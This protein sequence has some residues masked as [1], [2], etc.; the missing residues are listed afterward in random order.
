MGKRI[1]FFVLLLPVFCHADS[2]GQIFDDLINI[3]GSN[4]KT[5]VTPMQ[6]VALQIFALLF[7]PETIWIV[8]KKAF[9]EGDHGKATTL[10]FLRI[11]SGGFFVYWIMN[12]DIFFAIPQY[13]AQAGSK[14]G[15]FSVTPTGDF[16]IMPSAIMNL[17]GNFTDAL[18]GQMVSING[19]RDIATLLYIVFLSLIVMFCLTIISLMLTV[20]IIETYIVICGALGLVGFVGSS[21]TISYFQSYLR[22]VIALGVKL[23]LM[24]LITGFFISRVQRL[25]LEVSICSNANVCSAGKYASTLG[26]GCILLIVFA[27]LIYHIPNL[28]SS[29]LSGNLNM[30]YGGIGSAAAAITAAAASPITVASAATRSAASIGSAAYSVGKAGAALIK[31]SD[32][33]PALS[34]SGGSASS[35]SSTTEP[36]SKLAK[37][38]ERLKNASSH[39]SVAG[40]QTRNSFGQMA[41]T[42]QKAAKVIPRSGGVDAGRG[43]NIGL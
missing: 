2:L 32:G 28:A 36:K 18:S 13:F 24:C 1:L 39:M 41:N 3:F 35:S 33:T 7:F 6:Q 27:Y 38:A 9:F 16:S 31:G 8:T 20:T 19:I 14:V 22:F 11:I 43:P 10:F 37:A 34:D 17:Y 15:G 25:A 4:A 40:Q 42:A 26:S 29:A 21:W 23:M 30:N 12:P 5:W